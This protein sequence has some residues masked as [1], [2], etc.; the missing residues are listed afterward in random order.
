MPA[1]I[2]PLAAVTLAVLLLCGERRGSQGVRWVFKPATSALF[3][4]AALM[5]GPHRPFD[6]LL[7]AGLALG[8][9]GDVALI[10]RSRRAFLAGLVA[11]LLGHLAYTAAFMQRADVLDLPLLPLGLVVLAG[12]GLFAYF[13]PYL[14]RMLWPVAAYAGVISLMLASAW[15]VVA[16]SA[17]APGWQLATGATLFYLSDITVARSRFVP[18]AEFTNRAVGLPLYYAAQFL[19]A[20]SVG[21]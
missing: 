2:L 10:P 17:D 6:W 5:Q 11:F 14:G 18:G 12:A 4:A 7:V 1:L 19:F 9:V 15:A 3:L 16:A 13:R 21:R 20:F 8:A